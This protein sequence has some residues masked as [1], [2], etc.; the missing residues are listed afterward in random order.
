[1]EKQDYNIQ[2]NPQEGTETIRV[3]HEPV[4][5]REIHE[6]NTRGYE[7]D[8]LQ[9]VMNLVVRKGTREH[10]VIFYT[11]DA[12][13]VI[14][15]D[16]I[17]D[18]PL[19]KATYAFTLSD[20]FDAWCELLNKRLTQRELVNSLKRLD[21]NELPQRDQLIANLRKLQVAT[22][23]TAGYEFDDAG[24]LNVAYRETNGREGIMALPNVI[25][26]DLPILNESDYQVM[27]E[28]ELELI[29]PKAD[30]E[31]PM[32]VLTCPKKDV[33]IKNAVAHEVKKLKSNLPQH[34]ILAGSW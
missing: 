22:V 7:L 13:R 29:K 18:R 23:I 16:S 9:A 8:S 21:A 25:N 34:L 26:P 17:Q 30:D 15:D 5:T 3:I 31:R 28:I 10:T 27:I 4:A 24:N 1:M 33:Y 2:I 19:D 32:I 14:L 11:E 20:Q 12:V 6:W